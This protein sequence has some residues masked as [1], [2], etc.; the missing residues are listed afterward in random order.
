M[1]F[2]PFCFPDLCRA[3]IPNKVSKCPCTPTVTEKV[4]PLPTP[5]EICSI[6]CFLASMCLQGVL[7]REFASADL[8]TNATYGSI[9]SSLASG[10][11]AWQHTCPVPMAKLLPAADLQTCREPP[12]QS[13]RLSHGAP[14][15]RCRVERERS[16]WRDLLFCGDQYDLKLLRL[17]QISYSMNNNLWFCRAS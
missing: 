2:K 3:L 9:N 5:G 10:G 14:T 15:F 6:R 7:Q 8:K 4:L 13:S 1:A 11:K 16:G 17:W 12:V